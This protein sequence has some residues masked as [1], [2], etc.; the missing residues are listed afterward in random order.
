MQC[1]AH[2]AALLDLPGTPDERCD[3]YG[4]GLPAPVVVTRGGLVVK[5]PG[6]RCAHGRPRSRV[7]AQG[8]LL[9]PLEDLQRLGRRG[10]PGRVLAQTV[11]DQLFELQGKVQAR[12][13]VAQKLRGPRQVGREQVDDRRPLEHRH[14]GQQVEAHAPQSVDVGR[15]PH[16]GGAALLGGHELGRAH[17][18][19]LGRDLG[20]HLVGDDA[21]HAEVH[22][23]DHRRGEERGPVP[24]EQDVGRLEVPVHDALLVGMV[25]GRGQLAQHAHR[26]GHGQGPPTYHGLVGVHPLDVL[27]HQVVQ[28][29]RAVQVAKVDDLDDVR[30]QQA[31]QG[32]GLTPE[33]AALV[34][35]IGDVGADDLERPGHAEGELLRQVDLTHGPGAEQALHLEAVFHHL[36]HQPPGRPF[37]RRSTHG[38]Q[39]T[40]C[41]EMEPSGYHRRIPDRNRGDRVIPRV[42]RGRSS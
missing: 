24:L 34:G 2:G 18:L 40:P 39:L 42:A 37:G 13:A 32:H 4:V 25:Q 5:L 7:N 6:V 36:S 30:V 21:N 38:V 29:V 22:H 35:R 11:V 20:Q 10:P 17:Q 9:H 12:A 1:H 26:V 28:G 33:A 27:Q 14:A 8:P 15:G 23:L 41:R 31:A 19:L 16:P 3:V